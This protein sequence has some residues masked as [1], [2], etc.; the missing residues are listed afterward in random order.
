VEL[1]RNISDRQPVY[2]LCGKA[3]KNPRH[4]QQPSAVVTGIS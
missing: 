3:I 4:Q 1:F 2:K